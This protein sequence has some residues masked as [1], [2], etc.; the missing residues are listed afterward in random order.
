MSAAAPASGP[1]PLPGRPPLS[2][3]MYHQV[4][5]FTAPRNHRA[6]YCH[7]HR[8]RT[9][10]AFLAR[11]G[12]RVL[13][14]DAAIAGLLG[15]GEL[16]P[17]GVVLSFDDGYRNFRE[18]ALPVLQHYGFPAA[19]YM[20]SGLVGGRAEWLGAD[21]RDTPPMLS[22]SELR[23]LR[24]A[25]ITVGSHTVSHPR[26]SRLAADAVARELRD[27]KAQLEDLL[28]EAVP[29]FC[30]PYGDYSPS[31]RDAVIDA[32]Y[33]SALSCIR[34]AANTADNVYE[35]PRKAISYGDNL[36]GYW[37]K[38]AMKNARKD[39]RGGY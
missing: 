35:L 20:I 36:L 22:A 28:G 21:G 18:H 5:E 24:Q 14:L 11:A 17:R 30:Y 26:L 27:S 9:Q 29:H 10:M 23:E 25:G 37:W 7:V 33:R 1:R 12:Y 3:L 19:V 13:S 16:P 38:L 34:G 4:G 6:G 2:I 31:V 32:G 15:D 39:R 8:F